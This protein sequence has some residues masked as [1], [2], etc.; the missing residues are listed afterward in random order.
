LADISTLFADISALV[1]HHKSRSAWASFL[2][3][4]LGIKQS[5][6]DIHIQQTQ[7]SKSLWKK[8]A[9]Y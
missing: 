5:E 9:A 8:K 6:I 1:E 7:F 2:P 4:N 3:Y